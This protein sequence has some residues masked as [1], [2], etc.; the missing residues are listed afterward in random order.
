[1]KSNKNTDVT[2][3]K[4]VEEN[5]DVTL[6]KPKV[7]RVTKKK[8]EKVYSEE[9]LNVTLY[10]EISS[11]IY[12]SL[13]NLIVRK[14]IF[15]N[16]ELLKILELQISNL[17]FLEKELKELKDKKYAIEFLQL[18]SNLV[19]R[20]LSITKSSPKNR[21]EILEERNL[22]IVTITNICKT[23]EKESLERIRQFDDNT[24]N[25]LNDQITALNNFSDDVTEVK[26]SVTPNNQN[27]DNNVDTNP[28][29]VGIG[30]L[31]NNLNVNNLDNNSLANLA[32][33]GVLPQHPATNPKFYPYMNKPKY[34]PLLKKILSAFFL[35]TTVLAIATYILTYFIAGTCQIKDSS[36]SP[37]YYNFAQQSKTIVFTIVTTIVL[38]GGFLYSILKPPKLGR[39]LYWTSYFLIVILIFWIIYTIS[40]LFYMTTDDSLL[41]TFTSFLDKGDKI[42]PNAL[43]WLKGLATFKAFQILTYIT[44]ASA[45]L[46]I[47]IIL[48]I[49]ILN[50]KIDRNKIM[51]ANSEYQNA[52][53]NALSG[54]PYEIDPS[55]FDDSLDNDNKKDTKDHKFWRNSDLFK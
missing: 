28:N 25:E 6:V 21:I 12:N 3:K 20:S 53:N 8:T 19:N 7:K 30:N 54:K 24:F 5:S 39:D 38:N 23:V 11:T 27:V 49:A 9:D 32:K 48:V 41:R 37:V 34:I 36:T 42:N 33:L 47:A 29:I 35:L 1:M 4:L 14:S 31:G 43:P 50:P 18:I 16:E 17:F 13:N 22:L 45:I 40:N 46:P 10:Y 44:A 55:L 26:P 51:R 2:E 52:I 15:A